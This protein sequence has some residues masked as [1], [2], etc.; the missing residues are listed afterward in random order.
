MSRA[1]PAGQARAHAPEPIHRPTL[2]LV[3]ALGVAAALSAALVGLPRE[4]AH[5]PAIARYAMEISLPRWHITEP[6]SELVYGTRGFDTFGETFLLLA[7]VVSVTTL[8]RRREPRQSRGGEERAGEREQA[9]IDPAGGAATPAEG[10]ARTAEREEHDGDGEEDADSDS[11]GDGDGPDRRENPD[12]V[13]LGVPGPED[14]EAMSV[15]V[16]TA[17]RAAA[18][19]LGVIG[20]YLVAW[21]YTPGGGFPA[22]AVLVGVVLLVYA[23]F[24]YRRIAP[25]VRPGRLEAVELAGALAIIAIG[26]GGL[27][28]EGSFSANFLPLAAQPDT[29]LSGGVIQAFSASELFEVSTGLALAIF[30]LLAMEHDWSPD[31]EA[32]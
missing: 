2:A 30:A 6:V 25:F 31:E 18:P 15:V 28:L 24:G 11:H 8:T 29:I 21:G 16:R 19:I 10:R 26:V 22:G 14:A 1:D 27:V 9:E 12:A 7:A 5:L 17:A 23:G 20:V 3:L 32:E 4:R 13:G